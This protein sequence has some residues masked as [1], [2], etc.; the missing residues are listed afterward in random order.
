MA[1]K[2][3]SAVQLAEVLQIYSQKELQK[4]TVNTNDINQLLTR[5]GLREGSFD[6]RF[7]TL[8]SFHGLDV[9]HSLKSAVAEGLISE[10]AADYA[11]Q[12][13]YNAIATLSEKFPVLTADKWQ[14]IETSISNLISTVVEQSQLPETLSRNN[15]SALTA[16]YE[17]LRSEFNKPMLVSYVKS[18]QGKQPSLKIIHNSFKNFRDTINSAIKKEIELVLKE[19]KVTNSKLSEVNFLTTKIL[20]WGHTRTEES[21][22]SGKL[23]A[24]LISLKGLNP[25]NEVYEVISKDFIKETG[26][27]NTQIKLTRGELTKGD[28]KVLSLVIQSQYLQKVAVQY[29]GY[30]QNVLGKS[31]AKWNL[32]EAIQRN[33]QLKTALGINDISEL[34][35]LLLNIKSSPSVVD[36]SIQLIKDTLAKKKSA[37]TSKSTTILNIKEPVVLKSKKVKVKLKSG[38]G[39]IPESQQIK[40]QAQT[41]NLISLQMLLDTHLQDVVSANM[42]D[43]SRTDILNYRTGRFAASAKVERLS[44]SREGMITAF[45]SYMKNPY[46]TFSD[47]GRQ[48]IPRSRDPKLLISKSIKEIAAE[49]V[50]NRM[51]TVLA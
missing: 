46:A 13:M 21:I 29:A 18:G 50:A 42:G 40:L 1:N 4:T 28:K 33:P 26:Q 47:A 17:V 16:K 43:G 36:S 41:T 30:N 38:T 51:R 37:R 24:S 35:N 7:P 23:I 34:P 20:N 39:A 8:F 48:S 32:A 31:E 6:V 15:I 22:V 10:I 11:L 12:G 44:E 3:S 9:K 45:Y 14:A 49:K 19:N 25:S 27:V 2:I 5:A